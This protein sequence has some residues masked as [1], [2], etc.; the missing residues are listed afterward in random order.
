MKL[1]YSIIFAVPLMLILLMDN[2]FLELLAPDNPMLQVTILNLLV[3]GMAALSLG[4]SVFYFHRMS[5]FMRFVFGLLL[6]YL[7]ALVFE[8]Y[9]KYNTF[10]VYPHVFLKLFLFCYIFFIYT[11]HKNNPLPHFKHVVWFT[12]ISFAL[13]AVLIHPDALSLSAFT[14]HERGIAASSVYMLVI[15]F[16]F[17][18]TNYFYKGDMANLFGALFLAFLLIFFQH[19][20]VWICTALGVAIYYFLIRYKVGKPLHI[21]AKLM[22]IAL[23]I[24]AAG[25]V[26]SAFV[27][28]VYPEVIE[29]FQESFSD[30][31]NF[32]SQ[33][34]GAWRYMQWISYWPFIEENPFFGMRFEGFELPIQFYNDDNDQPVFEDGN[35]HFFHSFYVDVLFY[36]GV[37]GLVIYILLIYYLISRA[38]RAKG[39]TGDQIVLLTFVLTGPL[40][41]F[42]YVFTPFYYGITGWCIAT[43]EEDG[44]DI[45]SFLKESAQRMMARRTAF[46]GQKIL[47]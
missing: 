36:L 14:S 26:G 9:Y 18:L 7:S 30:I 16:F 46:R 4:Y 1:N 5:P 10:M 6:L 45:V 37:A 20:T 2:M 28:S 17:F 42:S 21:L 11:F 23:I 33:G 38:V 29:K 47:Q 31:E 8:S 40:F 41:G 43:M 34:T 24:M 15:P 35:G 25:F 39:L 27:F 22:P 3:K 19:R 12:L 44:E 32:E 13:N